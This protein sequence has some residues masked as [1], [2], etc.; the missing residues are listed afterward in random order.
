MFKNAR[1]RI[2]GTLIG[3]VDGVDTIDSRYATKYHRYS[4]CICMPFIRDQWETLTL[5]H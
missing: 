1:L 3:Q 2:T 5:V 4:F